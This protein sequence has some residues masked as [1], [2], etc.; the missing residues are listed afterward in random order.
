MASK[1]TNSNL[2]KWSEFMTFYRIEMD[3]RKRDWDENPKFYEDMGART[4]SKAIGL[5]YFYRWN[6]T[7]YRWRWVKEG[8]LTEE[9]SGG[10]GPRYTPATP[11]AQDYIKTLHG[12]N[13]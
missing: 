13:T 12:E 8:W 4:F 7:H 5:S 2:Q 1:P 6:F 9:S 3:R 11:A 10:S